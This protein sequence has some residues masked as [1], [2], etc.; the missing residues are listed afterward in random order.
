[1]DALDKGTQE[2]R[3]L[4]LATEFHNSKDRQARLRYL[5]QM[6]LLADQEWPRA[7]ECRFHCVHWALMLDDPLL[8]R[9]CITEE[10]SIDHAFHA[11]TALAWIELLSGQKEESLKHANAAVEHDIKGAH[12]QEIRLLAEVFFRLKEYAHAIDLLERIA[13]PGFLD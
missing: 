6:K 1:L 13:I 11:N 3:F 9:S 2:G 4:A 10:F 8:A 7:V 12:V 5:E